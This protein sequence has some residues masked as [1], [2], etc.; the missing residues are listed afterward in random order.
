MKDDKDKYFTM[1]IP[2]SIHADIKS[3]CAKMRI[4]MKEFCLNSLMSGLN[5][6]VSSI[7]MVKNPIILPRRE[8][9]TEA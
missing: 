2:S 1:R 8:D 9:E 5:F 7:E 4:T 6:D 3:H